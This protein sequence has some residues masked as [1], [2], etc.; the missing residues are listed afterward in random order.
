MERF[1]RFIEDIKD[2]KEIIFHK[3]IEYKITY[4]TE[5]TYYFNEYKLLD[6]N[7]KEYTTGISK[8]YKGKLFKVVTI[9]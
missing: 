1:C 3:D 5:D 6:E 4:E 2:D 7:Q 8:E 9:E